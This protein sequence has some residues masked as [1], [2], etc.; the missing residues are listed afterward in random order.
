[1]TI[2]DPQGWSIGTDVPITRRKHYHIVYDPQGDPRFSSRVFWE[3]IEWLEAES[4]E[5]Y[6]L[7]PSE[8]GRSF[9][10]RSVLVT[11]EK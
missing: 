1:M 2:L 11:K 5:A 7:R 6:R 8:K 3:C 4:V 9:A 10:M